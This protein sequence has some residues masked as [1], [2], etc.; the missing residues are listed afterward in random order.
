M[1]NK[2]NSLNHL[3]SS[4]WFVRKIVFY[5]THPEAAG[6][7]RS[8]TAPIFQEK[9]H[10]GVNVSRRIWGHL[11][12]CPPHLRLP[13]SL[14]SKRMA[15]PHFCLSCYSPMHLTSRQNFL[16]YNPRCK[17]LENIMYPLTTSLTRWKVALWLR[18]SVQNI[19]TSATY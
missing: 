3:M 2:C 10:K 4:L 7:H 13:S 18:E 19:S 6:S 17:V 5:E 14:S 8:A 9:V 11:R 15:S 1:Y 16:H 12:V